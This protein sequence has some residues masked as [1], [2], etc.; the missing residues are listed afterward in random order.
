MIRKSRKILPRWHPHNGISDINPHFRTQAPVMNN[1]GFAK[2]IWRNVRKRQKPSLWRHALRTYDR[3]LELEYPLLAPS[4][5]SSNT[6]P[7][8]TTTSPPSNYPSSVKIQPTNIHHEGAMV[9]CAKLGLWERAL[10]IYHHVYEQEVD[11][12]QYQVQLR[13]KKLNL[14]SPSTK[15]PERIRQKRRVFITDNMI[16]SL[17]RACVR[18]SKEESTWPSSSSMSSQATPSSISSPS[19]S[20]TT[21]SM[22]GGNGTVVNGQK[23]SMIDPVHTNPV[24]DPRRL[25]LDAAFEIVKTMEERHKIPLASAFVNPIAAAYQALGYREDAKTVITTLLSNRTVGEEPENGV[26]IVNVY[27]FS[28]KDKGS[29]SLL[30]QGAVATGNW[31]EAVEALGD[32]TEAGL[33]PNARHL[34]MWTEISE[35]QSRSR[36][37]GSWKK[38]RNDF[39]SE[40]VR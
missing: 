37:V 31:A 6:S 9:A 8:E 29:Y 26:D 3:M 16:L 36:A 33:Y 30:V 27:D 39:W 32:M 38:K 40:S 5:S 34:N 2:S 25:P 17:I 23:E 7:K 12:K 21:N 28:A 13:N 20:T 22:K 4:T 11:Y 19:S 35:R 14:L 24:L 1:Q 10:Q 15:N 18:A